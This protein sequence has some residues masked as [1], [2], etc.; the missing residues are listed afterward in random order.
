MESSFS[1]YPLNRFIR[2]SGVS[3][4]L[5]GTPGKS[6][7]GKYVCDAFCSVCQIREGDVDWG[8]FVGKGENFGVGE[9]HGFSVY[10]STYGSLRLTKLIMPRLDEILKEAMRL[11][12]KNGAS[13][14]VETLA[15]MKEMLPL[16]EERSPQIYGADTN[17]ACE[18]DG[19]LLMVAPGE[20]A[21]LHDGDSHIFEEVRVLSFVYSPKGMM[22]TLEPRRGES[23]WS[24]PRE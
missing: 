23:R 2:T 14:V 11:A 18:D 15:G 21:I 3:F 7:A 12:E 8:V 5:S 16:L 19:W 4:L 13:L 6:G 22:Y 17:V 1:Q 9:M 24:V 20:K 10:D